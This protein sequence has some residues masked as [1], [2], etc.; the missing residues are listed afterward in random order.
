V[1]ADLNPDDM[2]LAPVKKRK[3]AIK[4]NKFQDK[5]V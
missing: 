2:T 5:A 1:C 3:K 4:T